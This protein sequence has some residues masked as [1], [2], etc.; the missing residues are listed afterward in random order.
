[1]FIFTALF[2]WRGTAVSFQ[3]FPIVCLCVAVFFFLYVLN[4]R[5]LKI[6]ITEENVLLKFGIIRWRTK[7]KNI[8]SIKLDESPAVIKYGGAGVHFAFMKGNYRAFFNFLEYPR[9]HIA[10]HQKR[11]PVQGLVFTTRNPDEVLRII[12]SR[13][14]MK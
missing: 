7:L 11:G 1:M 12:Q 13:I 9:L 14:V 8:R 10:F 5:I 4:F 2:A 3:T 6:T